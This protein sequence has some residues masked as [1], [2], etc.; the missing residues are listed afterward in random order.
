MFFGKKVSLGLDIGRYSVKAA[1]LSPNKKDAE[2]LAESVIFP[3]REYYEQAPADE[4]VYAAIRKTLE[5]CLGPSSKVKTAINASFQGEGVC[6][7]YVEL[8]LLKPHEL[9]TAVQSMAAKCL[10]FPLKEAAISHFEVPPLSRDR[11]KTGIFL[12]TFKKS[13]LDEQLVFL[14]KSGIQVERVEAYLI[15]ML[16]DLTVNHGKA[17]EAFVALVNIGFNLTTLMVMKDGHPYYARDFAIAGRDFTYAFQM[18]AKCTWKEAEHAKLSYDVAKK[19]VPMEPVLTRWL[20]QVRKT[21][22]TASR[23]D[24][25]APLPIEKVYLSGGSAPWKGLLE[26]V[27]ETV[28]I[29][30]AL[31]GWNHITPREG[32]KEPHGAFAIAMGL[33]LS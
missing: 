29:P 18:G 13:A 20:D 25:A 27:Q 4:E 3:Q 9:E 15:S 2:A 30:V 31:D 14:Q 28:S 1:V 21:L 6:S 16:R 22:I 23:I 17:T 12:M 7:N 19:D 5:S 26:R 32:G 24:K 11:H 10:P 8:P 33:A